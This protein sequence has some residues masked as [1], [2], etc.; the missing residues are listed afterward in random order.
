M[1]LKRKGDWEQALVLLFKAKFPD[2]IVF[3][4]VA[5][6]CAKA[7]AWTSAVALL[8]ELRSRNSST[9]D[10]AFLNSVGAACSSAGRWQFALW[11]LLGAPQ[12][13]GM[14]P[15]VVAHSTAMTACERVSLWERVLGLLAE[16]QAGDLAGAHVYTP[17]IVACGTVSAWQRS[18]HLWTELCQT[19]AQN[20]IAL[21]ATLTASERAGQWM[22]CL[23]LLKKSIETPLPSPKPDGISYSAVITACCNARRWPLAV[24]LLDLAMLDSLTPSTGAFSCLARALGHDRSWQ[25]ALLLLQTPHSHGNPWQLTMDLWSSVAWALDVPCIEIDNQATLHSLR[26]GRPHVSCVLG[27]RVVTL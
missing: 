17:A 20:T 27:A 3:T 24:Q 5:S 8:E 10:R 23:Q 7:T 15:C 19:S 12:S 13:A 22:L 6:V 16:S 26:I 25:Q 2:V 21:N 18:L 9:L 1:R 11:L 4:A 14:M